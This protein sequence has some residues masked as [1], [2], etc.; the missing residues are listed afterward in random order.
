MKRTA[1]IVAGMFLSASVWAAGLTKSD[2]N[3][4]ENA[5]QAG[6]FEIEGSKLAAT[7]GASGDVKSFAD[8][9]IQDHTAVGNE[10][11]QLA[12]S[13][14]VQVSTEPSLIQKAKLKVLGAYKGASFDKHYASEVGVSAHQDAVKLF[15]TASRKAKDPDVK[16]FATKALP[17]LQHHLAMAQSLKATADTE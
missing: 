11:D 1:L 17:Q 6:H 15:Q 12:S 9:M 5:A 2:Q 16:A 7:Q 14:G 10:L 3:F 8:Q 4:L 13:K